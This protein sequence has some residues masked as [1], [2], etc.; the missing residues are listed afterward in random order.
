MKHLIISSLTFLVASLV[1]VPA[2]VADSS[3]FDV[4]DNSALDLDQ[5]SLTDRVLFN[6]TH[7]DGAD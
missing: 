2:A 4:Q 6:R 5:S 3:A 7:R 1:L